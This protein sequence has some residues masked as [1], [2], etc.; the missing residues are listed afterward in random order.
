MSNMA[1]T[2]DVCQPVPKQLTGPPAP[3][4]SGDT[5][6]PLSYTQ[7]RLRQ[8]KARSMLPKRKE[9]PIQLEIVGWGLDDQAQPRAPTPSRPAHRTQASGTLTI[10]PLG[11]PVLRSAVHRP[12]DVLR[13]Q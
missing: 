7:G 1:R 9:P 5:H 6:L 13:L 2:R 11:V 4:C 8:V 3:A 12:L 10:L